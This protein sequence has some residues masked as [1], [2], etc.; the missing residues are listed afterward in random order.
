LDIVAILIINIADLVAFGMS[1][2]SLMQIVVIQAHIAIA[3][4][5]PLN[6]LTHANN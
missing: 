4:D 5:A 2:E 6:T 3:A 1:T